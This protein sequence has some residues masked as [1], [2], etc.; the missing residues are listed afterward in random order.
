MSYTHEEVQRMISAIGDNFNLYKGKAETRFESFDREI[1]A[2]SKQLGAIETVVAQS[3]FPGGGGGKKKPLEPGKFAVTVDGKTIPV[4]AKG[5]RMADLFPAPAQGAWSI[6]DFVRASMGMQIR[7]EVLERGTA[8]VPTH[9][10]S[11]IIDAVREKARIMRAGAITIPIEGKTTI[12]RIDGDPTV[13]E[14]TEGTSDIQESIPVFSPVELNPKTLAALIPLSLEIVQDSPNLDAA[15]QASISAA[16]ALKLDQLGIAKILAD[17][18]IPTSSEAEATNDWAGVLKAVGSMLEA[19]Q[20]IPKAMICSPGDFISRAS[21]VASSSGVWLGAP[22]ALKDMLD[23]E[24]SGMPGGTAILG[25]FARG[26]GIAVRHELRLE[27]V[28]WGKPTYGSHVLVAFCRMAGYVL[29][30]NH[31]YIAQ[32]TVDD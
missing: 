9:I 27:L 3:Q 12:A 18:N 32:S 6:G 30:P 16:F 25:D 7:G 31:L 23:L 13:Y 5:E 14:H 11:Q 8:T 22:P 15:L 2:I 28:R 19:D 26:F 10:A 21:Q 24:T 29:Q 17:T 4:L 20:E 1:E